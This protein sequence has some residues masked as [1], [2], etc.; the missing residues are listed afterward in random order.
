MCIY[1]FVLF[2]LIIFQG[3]MWA[4][5]VMLRFLFFMFIKVV[6]RLLLKERHFPMF[7][8]SLTFTLHAHL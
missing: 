3:K 5:Q 8:I 2:V 4:G 7:K 1:L 6:H